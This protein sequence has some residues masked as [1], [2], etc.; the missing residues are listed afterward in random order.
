MATG[1]RF[2]SSIAGDTAFIKG[3]GIFAYLLLI[4]LIGFFLIQIDKK[5]ARSHEWRIAERVFFIFALLGA[6]IGEFISMLLIR[7][8]TKHFTFIIGIPVITILVYGLFYCIL[9]A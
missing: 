4:N 2:F 6:G 7:H 8:K 3:F 1:I 5:K 9:F